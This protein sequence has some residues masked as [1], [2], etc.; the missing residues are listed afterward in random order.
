VLIIGRTERFQCGKQI[1]SYLGLVPSSD[2]PRSAMIPRL[3]FEQARHFERYRDVGVE[4]V[5]DRNVRLAAIIAAIE[6]FLSPQLS[7]SFHSRCCR[8]AE[9]PH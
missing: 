7:G 1:A 8:L 2:G 5:R 4:K 9:E 3:L 6:F